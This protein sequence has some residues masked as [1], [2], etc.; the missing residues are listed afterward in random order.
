MVAV[1]TM[2]SSNLPQQ[3]S[4]VAGNTSTARIRAQ[5]KEPVASKRA[6]VVQDTFP[7]GKKKKKLKVR[8]TTAVLSAAIHY[9][10]PGYVDRRAA[11]SSSGTVTSTSGP[12][13]RLCDTC[14]NVTRGNDRVSKV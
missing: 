13:L 1:N 4:Q 2:A 5:N 8:V 11:P 6:K 10:S 7:E 14:P 12:K 3:L 9:I